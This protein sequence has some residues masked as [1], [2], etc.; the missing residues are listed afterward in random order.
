MVATVLPDRL[1]QTVAAREEAE[2]GGIRAETVEKVLFTLVLRPSRQTAL[3]A[4]HLIMMVSSVPVEAE[5]AALEELEAVPVDYRMEVK[6]ETAAALEALLPLR[7]EAEAAARETTGG[8]GRTETARR[9]VVPFTFSRI[10]D[11]QKIRIS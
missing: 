8:G 4:E 1:P 6:E 10:R 3:M 11:V 2:E 5:A 9:E 7:A